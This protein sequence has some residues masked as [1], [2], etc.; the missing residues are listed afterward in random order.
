MKRIVTVILAAVMLFSC[1]YAAAAEDIIETEAVVETPVYFNGTLEA[2][3]GDPAVSGEKAILT[4]I[5]KEANLEYALQ[6]EKKNGEG[7]WTAIP[8]ANTER[9]EFTADLPAGSHI[10]RA[11]LSAADG[12][13]LTA[14]ATLTVLQPEPEPVAEPEPAAEPEQAKVEEAP[15]VEESKEEPKEEP[16]VEAALAEEAPAEETVTEEALAAEPEAEAPAEE[17]EAEVPAGEAT[18]EVTEPAAEVP[19]E[20]VA[21]EAP[22]EEAPAEEATEE[23]TEEAIE[24]PAEV[25]EEETAEEVPEATEPEAEVPAEEVTEEAAEEVAEE[26]TEEATEPE[27]EVPAEEVPEELEIEDYETPLGIAPAAAETEKA[28]HVFASQEG[29]FVN[30][31]STIAGFEGIEIRYQWECDKHDGAGFQNV[32][33]ANES[34]YKYYATPENVHWEWRLSIY[35]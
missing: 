17:T 5:V 14:E 29:N 28:V 21:V 7:T 22:A 3:P 20:E 23:V 8:G 35:F 13:I 19:A 16:A 25:T 24:V 11:V 34:T 2:R 33:G 30:L 1:L 15:A 18:E 6:W 9:Y 27:T 31:T 10:F 32:D 4:A 12:T 26:V